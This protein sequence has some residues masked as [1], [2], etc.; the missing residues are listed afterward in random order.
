MRFPGYLAAV[1]VVLAGCVQQPELIASTTAMVSVCIENDDSFSRALGV[2]EAECQKAGK[3]ALAIAGG[4]GEACNNMLPRH[5]VN[6][7][8]VAQ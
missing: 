8:C 3:H 4:T 1:G 2:A 7:E 5:V 6:F